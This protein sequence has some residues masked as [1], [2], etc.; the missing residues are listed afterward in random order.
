LLLLL[1]LLLQ[2]HQQETSHD[3]LALLHLL[4]LHLLLLHLLSEKAQKLWVHS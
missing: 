1:L 3:G 4:L 2:L